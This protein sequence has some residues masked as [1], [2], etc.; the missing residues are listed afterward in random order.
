[1]RVPKRFRLGPHEIEVQF[2][3]QSEIND[4][5]GGS[6]LGLWVPG[7]LT[8]YLAKPSK[9]LKKEVQLHTF[10][11]EYFHALYWCLGRM[12]ESADE[13]LVD[14]CGLLTMQALQSAEY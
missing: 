8:I 13:V 7:E 10:W 3:L 12:D 5:A 4:K 6:V 9:T 14:Q 2:L 1:M 11:H